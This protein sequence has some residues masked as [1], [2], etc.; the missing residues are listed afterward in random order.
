MPAMKTAKSEKGPL[1]YGELD[2]YNTRWRIPPL[3]REGPP[4]PLGLAP[5]DL[6]AAVIT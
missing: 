2:E 3:R 1:R 4:R 5:S 6:F